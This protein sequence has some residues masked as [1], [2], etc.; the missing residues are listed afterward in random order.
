VLRLGTQV[1]IL[2]PT[3]E[4]IS[5]I[6]LNRLDNRI[7]TAR[8]TV[9][10]RKGIVRVFHSRAFY[11]LTPTPTPPTP[12]PPPHPSSPGNRSPSQGV[13]TKAS[14]QGR[15]SAPLTCPLPRMGKEGRVSRRGGDGFSDELNG[16]AG[17]ATAGFEHA[18]G[19]PG[20]P[21]F[22]FG[23]GGGGRWRG[24]VREARRGYFFKQAVLLLHSPS[25]G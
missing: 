21:D 24:A 11:P 7:R 5:S 14:G 22:S 16:S 9:R 23:R 10:R 4:W 17:L 8:R 19:W 3:P 6:A 18:T 15:E 25:A 2:A 12:P 1:S 13:C 20:T